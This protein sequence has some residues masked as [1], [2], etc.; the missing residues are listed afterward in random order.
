MIARG[1]I[2]GT[3]SADR[4]R[5]RLVDYV[6]IVAAAALYVVCLVVLHL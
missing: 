3:V 1:G 5:P 2:G 4:K 6:V